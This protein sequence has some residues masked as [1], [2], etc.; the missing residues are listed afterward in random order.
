MHN[1]KPARR[2][3]RVRI[4]I[5]VCNLTLISVVSICRMEI[6]MATKVLQK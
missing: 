4:Q 3:Y 2:C 5:N 6:K 1:G